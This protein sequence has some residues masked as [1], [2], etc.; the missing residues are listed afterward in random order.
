MFEETSLWKK[1][2]GNKDHE[3]AE[4]VEELRQ[5]YL[6]FRKNSSFLVS[7]IATILPGLT[8][9]EISHLDSLWDTASL[10]IGKNYP[11]N[12]LEGFI[13]GGAILLHDSALCFEAFQGGQEELRGTNQ[14]K[15]AFSELKDGNSKLNEQSLRER[16]DF[17]ALRELHALQAEKLLEKSWIDPDNGQE[18]YLLEDFTLRKHFGKLIGK[19]A[20][21]H[22]W[23]I[24]DLELK[25]TAQQ[26]TLP[27]YPRD[28]RI[29]P[30]KIACILRCADAAH[31]DNKRAPDFLHALLNRNGISFKHWQA[32]NKI[33]KIDIDQSDLKKETLLFTSTSE[34]QEKDADSWYIIYD[35][36]NLVHK[37]I[38]SC[39]SLLNKKNQNLSFQIKKVAGIGSPEELS[40]FVRVENWK[41]CSAEVHVS[42]IEKLIENL[43]GEMLYGKGNDPFGIAIRELVQNSRD[44]INARLHYDTAFKGFISLK[45]IEEEDN[46]FLIVED[47]GI[48]MSER[49]LTGPLLDFGTS[50]WTSSLVKSE[51]PGLRSSKFR[52]IGRFGIGFYS[53]F[54]V[55]EQTIVASKNWNQGLSDIHLLK[56]N[57]GFTL[58]PI[59]KKGMIE[60][61]H[62]SLSTRIKIK[63][64]KD[65]IS[66]DRLIEIK[67]NSANSE[68]FKVPFAT[69][70]SA[71]CSGLDV[72]VYYSPQEFQIGEK[73]HESLK[74]PLLN[75]KK[76][77]IDF[78]FTEYYLKKENLDYISRNID[79]L[80]YIKEDNEVLG[81]AAI[82]TSIQNRD[83][84]LS[85]KSVGGLVHPVNSRNG[86]NYFGFID[87]SPKSAKRDVSVFSGSTEALNKWAIEQLGI[88]KKLKLN[89]LEC[90][91]S[92]SALC[93]FKTDPT[94]IAQ[95]YVSM[96][97][98]QYFLNFDQLANL[99]LERG[100]AFIQTGYS[101]G[102]HVEMHHK[103]KSIENYI[104][105]TPLLGGEFLSLKRDE[106][107]IPEIN[108]SILDCIYRKI[109][110]HGQIPNI[111]QIEKIGI[112]NFGVELNALVISS[113]KINY[114][115]D[116]KTPM[117]N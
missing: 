20:A 112:N 80:R 47:N 33:A 92:A 79:R 81:L 71:I 17:V 87:Y 41:P 40:K 106:N 96:D 117:L 88:L 35:A 30:V 61:F 29:D 49:V 9:H 84:F 22:H 26:N 100:I 38:S 90:Y 65:L 8:Q 58:R 11:I 83:R 13:L 107:N 25:L 7:R 73:I 23:E 42:N 50:F 3:N 15:D 1:T 103:I 109:Q 85:V 75:K 82:N 60:N 94:D 12:P 77:L 2:L 32:Q 116:L 105:V 39:N 57:K 76:W 18:I 70:L 10:I 43:G 93:H 51:F 68:N 31:I 99:S 36:V 55:A 114:N 95:I 48:G 24:E 67:L 78:S 19:I 115:N 53:I 108:Y 37:E 6:K 5:I 111:F 56:F 16:A 113:S 52:A 21:S 28:W 66:K 64:K 86:S 63:L 27:D 104:L 44:S 54:M 72:N 110:S 69:Y 45:L 98:K 46:F 97:E 34:F 101:D 4:K 62:P 14:W 89:P 102:N 59:I 91:C 74:N